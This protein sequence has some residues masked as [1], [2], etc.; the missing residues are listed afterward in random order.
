L[1]LSLRSVISLQLRALPLTSV[2]LSGCFFARQ[3]APTVPED[4]ARHR[5]ALSTLIVV[6]HTSGPLT[7]AFRAATPPV[8][9]VNLGTVQAG[10]RTAVAPIPAGEPIVLI[11]RTADGGEFAL[12]AQSYPL[13]DVYT[14]EIAANTVF[15]KTVT[16]G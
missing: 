4:E 12:N 13:D 2:L 15:R 5:A 6:N 8:Q 1:N 9:E 16:R 11:A 10:I 3:G 14:W 7:I